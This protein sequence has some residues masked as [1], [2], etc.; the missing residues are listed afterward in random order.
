MLNKEKISAP[1]EKPSFLL[2]SADHDI[3]WQEVL[4]EALSTLGTLQVATEREAV[5]AII[6]HNY[7]AIILDAG[8]VENF[9]L[10]T[11]RICAQWPEARVIVITTSLTWKRARDAFQAGAVDY[12][13]KS[14]NKGELFRT[15]KQTLDK[16]AN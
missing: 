10:L 1:P 7:R 14:P 2:V 11:S 5:E 16:M 9:A 13:Y 15:I 6:A 12:L 4:T 3:Y 8:M